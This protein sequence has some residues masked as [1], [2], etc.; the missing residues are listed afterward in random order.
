[1]DCNLTNS[2]AYKT[3]SF[4]YASYMISFFFSI[5]LFDY[6]QHL[7]DV[8]ICGPTIEKMNLNVITQLFLKLSN[9]LI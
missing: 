6:Q 7:C 8:S 9:K 1:M 4:L 3:V 2:W 5:D